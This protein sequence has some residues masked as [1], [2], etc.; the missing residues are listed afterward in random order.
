MSNS[1]SSEPIITSL[2]DTDA[3]KFT[4]LQYL[5]EYHRYDRATA[6]LFVRPGRMDYLLKA[7]PIERIAEELHAVNEL[8]FSPRDIDALRS[9]LPGTSVGFFPWLQ[10]M[11]V[12]PNF[13]V[14]ADLD[15]LPVIQ[16]EG[17]W[18]MVSLWETFVMSILNELL[19]DKSPTKFWVAE[20]RL[21]SKLAALAATRANVV[22]FGTR[23]R[24]SK[25]WHT[26][27]YDRAME[28][29]ALT[30]TSNVALALKHG[31][32]PVGTMAH[33]LFMGEAALW[34]EA[35][36]SLLGSQQMVLQKWRK[37]YGDQF[38]IALTDTWTS[39]YFFQ[40]F[41]PAQAQ[42]WDGLRQDSGPPG[43]FAEKAK[44][45]Y[46]G[47]GVSPASKQIVFSDGLTLDRIMALNSE[48]KDTFKCVFGYGTNLTNDV[49]EPPPSIV[50]KITSVNGKPT[51]KLSDEPA[52]WLGPS[53][54]V[55]MYG[56]VFLTGRLPYRW[57]LDSTPVR[58]DRVL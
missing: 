48:W 2:L 13:K 57:L 21:K 8:R 49:G 6:R 12:A 9:W 52:K 56:H 14:S 40:D 19:M 26:R 58:V 10:D 44:S 32:K 5:H 45:F 36:S 1:S 54:L 15:G 30:G 29:G 43:V 33:E 39:D 3:Y 50:M 4:M 37:L 31:Q 47:A 24:A 46:L 16:V 38:S 27:V 34:D 17:P 11:R 25:E 28:E 7:V 22:D 55:A 42:A 18:T 53:D 41:T 51:V 20:S 23:R 35:P